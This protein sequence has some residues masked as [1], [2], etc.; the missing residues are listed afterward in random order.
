MLLTSALAGRR[1]PSVDTLASAAGPA[2]LA[3]DTVLLAWPSL[4][5]GS[6][7]GDHVTP[8]RITFAGT[9]TAIEFGGMLFVTTASAPMIEP[10]PI[11]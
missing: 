11:V 10:A 6:N 1:S 4:C 5:G 2:V 3:T 8:E 7:S 9:P